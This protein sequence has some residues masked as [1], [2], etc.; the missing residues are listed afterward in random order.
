MKTKTNYP[1]DTQFNAGVENLKKI[2]D[3]ME[4]MLGAIKAQHEMF[5]LLMEVQM[6]QYDH[7]TELAK[8][9]TGKKAGN[10]VAEDSRS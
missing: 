6:K 3:A 5:V 4:Q 7:I 9:I 10:N 1:P 8:L 2:L